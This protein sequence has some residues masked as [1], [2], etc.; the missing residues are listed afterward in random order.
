[1]TMAARNSNLGPGGAESCSQG[2][3]PLVD[4][5]PISPK[6]RRGDIAVANCFDVAPLGLCNHANAIN[7]GLAP[8]A[9]RRG[10]SGAI[11]RRSRR[12]LQLRG[13]SAFTLLEV[14]LALV[15]LAAALA[16]F[17]EIMQLANRNAVNARAETQ[18]QIL[19]E[20]LMDELL[21]GVVD[22]TQVS[23]QALEVDSPTPWVYSVT[24]GAS[25]LEGVQPVEVLVEQD[26]E[27]Q[28]NPVKFRLLRWL[29]TY[30]EMPES[31]GA[32]GGGQ[33]GGGQQGSG[34]GA[35]QGAQP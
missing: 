26:V 18:A 25:D 23:R 22:V 27:P 21:A 14:I 12:P 33:S 20:S 6:P 2:R 4:V 24:I 16:T 3:E 31:G 19:A 28:F 32:M 7:Q 1:M 15:I 5:D 17:G 8:L 9:T 13:H 10:P 30:V 29:P 35:G 11:G 34:G